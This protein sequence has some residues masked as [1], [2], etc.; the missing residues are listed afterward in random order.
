MTATHTSSGAIRTKLSKFMCQRFLY[1]GEKLP[2]DS[3]TS[4]DESLFHVPQK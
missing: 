1:F 2:V 4:G 3:L